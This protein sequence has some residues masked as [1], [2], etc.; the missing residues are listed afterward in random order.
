M[1]ANS[2]KNAGM[3]SSQ[4]RWLSALF[5]AVIGLFLMLFTFGVN[6]MVFLK[7]HVAN[8]Q[9]VKTISGN[10]K[11]VKYY[12]GG[13]SGEVMKLSLMP[14]VKKWVLMGKI[15]AEESALFVKGNQMDVEVYQW[16]DNMFRREYSQKHTLQSLGVTVNNQVVRS[17]KHAKLKAMNGSYVIVAVSLFGLLIGAFG[18]YYIIKIPPKNNEVMT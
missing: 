6:D 13:R 7:N 5:V 8:G 4:K 14:G 11:T 3:T 1:T 12:H 16:P 15:S 9:M 2:K 18:L 10:I 17:S